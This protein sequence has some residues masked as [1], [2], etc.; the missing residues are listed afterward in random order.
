LPGSQK[1]DYDRDQNAS[2]APSS[3]ASVP[4]PL[5]PAFSEQSTPRTLHRSP[6]AEQSLLSPDNIDR[7]D[8][9]E[10]DEGCDEKELGT[11]A[12][13]AASSRDYNPGFFGTIPILQDSQK[14]A[15]QHY[16]SWKIS[17]Q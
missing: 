9:Y 14:V 12:M 17:K 1:L 4:P 2:A 16:R 15:P 11:D 3:L 7:N 8:T 6:E 5:I 13:G 10:W